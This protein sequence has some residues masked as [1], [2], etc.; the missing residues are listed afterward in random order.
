M[1]DTVE[2]SLQNKTETINITTVN[3]DKMDFRNLLI[4]SAGSEWILWDQTV[5]QVRLKWEMASRTLQTAK[6]LNK[7]SQKIR[8]RTTGTE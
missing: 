7:M 2:H 5:T 1:S 3:V 4:V 6:M 8:N